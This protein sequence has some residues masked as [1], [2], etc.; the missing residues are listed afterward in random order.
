MYKRKDMHIHKK[1]SGWI[2]NLA[3]HMSGDLPRAD[4]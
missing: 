1:M 2:Q 4:C 3:V